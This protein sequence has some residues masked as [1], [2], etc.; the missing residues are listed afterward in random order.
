MGATW[1]SGQRRQ[2]ARDR[3]KGGG[4]TPFFHRTWSLQSGAGNPGLS[5]DPE[6][7]T[8]NS[9]GRDIHLYST[10]PSKGHL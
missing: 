3:G 9:R 10:I 6:C 5:L 2:T 7:L 1:L 8:I 4:D